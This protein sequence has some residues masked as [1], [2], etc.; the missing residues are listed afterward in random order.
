MNAS[1][2]NGLSLVGLGA[3]FPPSVLT[4]ADLASQLAPKHP[5]VTADWI[6]ERT[7]VHE[8]RIS[9]SQAPE[10]TASAL[11]ITSARRAI[12]SAGVDIA[13][14]DYI[15]VATFTA[16]TPLPSAAAR[17]AHGLGLTTVPVLDVHAACSGFLY[18]LQ[19]A[20]GLL[21]TGAAK[22]VLLVGVDVM[23]STVNWEDPTT[24][25]LFGDGAGAAVLQASTTSARRAHRVLVTRTAAQECI[26]L[27][28][29]PAGGSWIP[30]NRLTVPKEDYTMH[31]MGAEVREKAVSALV[32][33]CRST[34]AD[35]SMTASAVDW[36]VPHQANA[37]IVRDVAGELGIPF[38][39]VRMNI[40]RFG[41]TSAATIPTLLAE[42][43]AE[44]V[45]QEGAVV[46]LASFG[47]GF[48]IGSAVVR[49]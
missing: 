36:L 7:G 27:L 1:S 47:A 3:A 19:V 41:N 39:R 45:F 8:R 46:M 12:Q 43:D 5:H 38:S 20:E 33:H 9:R 24:C 32:E 28:Y 31:M 49:W 37:R 21:A 26:D 4:N 14:I 2:Q 17:V 34:L 29:I 40:D 25:I 6:V 22:T 15:L 35:L 42:A 16:D 30:R 48:T 23:S 10:D 13:T 44:G 11:G 18:G